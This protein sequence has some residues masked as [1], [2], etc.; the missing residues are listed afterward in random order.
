MCSYSNGELY[1][2]LYARLYD[3][4][5]SSSRLSGQHSERRADHGARSGRGSVALSLCATA[6]PLHTRLAA[7]FG[8]TPCPER[9]CDG[10]LGLMVGV[11]E[12]YRGTLALDVS[13]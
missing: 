6:H 2:E 12:R 13:F 8:A 11:G 4:V 1:A 9:R 7:M 3:K 10:T 5:L